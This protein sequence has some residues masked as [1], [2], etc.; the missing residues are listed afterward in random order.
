MDVIFD[1]LKPVTMKVPGMFHRVGVGDVTN[2]SEVPTV[3]TFRV[4]VCRLLSFFL[5][6]FTYLEKKNKRGS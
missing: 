4:E 6:Y 3:S 2:A 1:V 5:V